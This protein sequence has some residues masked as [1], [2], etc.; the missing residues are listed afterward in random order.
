[1]GKQHSAIII[2]QLINAH[3]QKREKHVTK[4]CTNYEKHF[5]ISYSLPSSPSIIPSLSPDNNCTAFSVMHSM[6][7]DV[8]HV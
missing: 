1:M 6:P 8:L 7:S 3:N 2:V 5:N 4:Q